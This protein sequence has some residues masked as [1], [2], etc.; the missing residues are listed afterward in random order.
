MRIVVASTL[1]VLACGG[2]GG[3]GGKVATTTPAGKPVPVTAVAG[4]TCADAA[5]LLRGKK[6]GKEAGGAKENVIKTS[7]EA[8]HWTPELLKCVTSTP[9]GTTCLAKLDATQR[10]AYDARIAAWVEAYGQEAQ[11]DQI[12]A[13]NFDEPPP[14]EDP[15]DPPPDEGEYI[16]CGEVVTDR[17]AKEFPGPTKEKVPADGDFV[18]IRKLLY[19]QTCNANER[20]QAWA[21]D[22]RKCLRDGGDTVTC[23]GK[24]EAA[25]V[26]EVAKRAQDADAI[27]KKAFELRKK[28]AAVGCAQ[29][30][31]AHYGDAMWKGKLDK[32][33]AKDRKAA[34]DASR[35]AMTKACTTDKWDVTERACMVGAGVDSCVPAPH[36]W[37]YP[38]RGVIY[39]TGV[40]ECDAYVAAMVAYASCKNTTPDIRDAIYQ[41]LDQMLQVIHDVPADARETLKSGCKSGG[42]AIQSLVATC[43]P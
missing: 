25:H 5:T 6:L 34:I 43:T 30:T 40:A 8:D 7:C 3:K 23:M 29:V 4:A 42:D 21:G 16:A 22:A 10:Q 26:G 12:D 36:A 28:P 18:K 19:V 11:D 39:P 32:L 31:A 37:G 9:D 41:S 2:G 24:L 1:F 20:G 14:R 33:A 38:A 27:A 15:E 17:L 35:A 13:H